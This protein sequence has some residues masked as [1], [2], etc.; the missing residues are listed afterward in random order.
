MNAIKSYLITATLLCVGAYWV[1]KIQDGMEQQKAPSYISNFDVCMVHLRHAE[2]EYSQRLNRK[3]D[4]TENNYHL[5][6]DD[7]L[8]AHIDWTHG[9]IHEVH[10]H[11]QN[12]VGVLADISEA[13]MTEEDLNTCLEIK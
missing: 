2:S 11:E 5:L 8:R 7:Y 9:H 10:I 6:P 12:S 1:L 3:W 4:G 13:G